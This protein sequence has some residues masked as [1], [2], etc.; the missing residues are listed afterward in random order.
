MNRP[1]HQAASSPR[2]LAVFLFLTTSILTHCGEGLVPEQVAADTI[3][4]N[5][6]V[7]SVNESF[8]IASAMAMASGSVKRKSRIEKA[9]GTLSDKRK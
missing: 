2:V 1:N 6:H 4:Y 9:T 3:F 7:I 8:S 5:G